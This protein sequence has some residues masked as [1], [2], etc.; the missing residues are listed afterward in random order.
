MSLQSIPTM[1]IIQYWF[2]NLNDDISSY[3][4]W[5]DQ[6]PDDYIKSNY[7]YLV[8][9]LNIDNYR[10]LINNGF[11][12]IALIIIGDQFTRNIYRNSDNTIRTKN[13]SWCL[14]LVL[15][16]LKN[17][18]DLNY[19]LNMRYFI[20]LVLRH[21]K[22]SVYM[23]QALKH[24]E[25]Y[26]DFYVENQKSVPQSL[27]KFYSHTIKSYT[28]LDDLIKSSSAEYYDDDLQLS[29]SDTKISI[30]NLINIPSYTDILDHMIY[31]FQNNDL[32]KFDS[33]DKLYMVIYKWL[34]TFKK[35]NLNIGVSLS[36]GVDSMVLLTIL[37]QI[38]YTNPNLVSN[39]IAIHIEH[40]NRPEAIIE[41]DFLL[42]Y[43]KILNIK[44]YYRT[45]YWMNRDTPNLNREIYESESKKI[46]F[47][48]YRY[49]I[50]NDDLI[51]MC[52]G[53][54]MGDITE[55]V[56][57]NMIKGKSTDNLGQMKKLDNQLDVD[58][59]LTNA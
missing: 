30:N 22:K 5:F 37:S 45:I 26:I 48:L 47:G 32:S 10:S 16:M 54:H 19:N 1:D 21:Q 8:D 49:A 42:A 28:E 27:L 18:E 59:H 58:I 13:D 2:K 39:I 46:R 35:N 11:D 7:Q 14:E 36:G 6:S 29:L 57:T 38:K 56:F 55:N 33:S 41:R 25:S 4:F 52:M 3:D 24:I 17:N 15:D 31:Q 44:L 53:H 12:K 34:G 51:G 9:S 23:D 20:I 43:C 40:M 50:I